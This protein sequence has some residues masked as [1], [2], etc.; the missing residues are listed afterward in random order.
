MAKD[1]NT[2]VKK[3]LELSAKDYVIA[4]VAVAAVGVGAYAIVKANS[5]G[6]KLDML[7]EEHAKAIQA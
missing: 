4:G 2:E 1:Q 6:K 3:G 7:L 5:T